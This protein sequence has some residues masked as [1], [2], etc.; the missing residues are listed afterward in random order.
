MVEC[1]SESKA[2]HYISCLQKKIWIFLRI[3]HSSYGSGFLKNVFCMEQIT[4]KKA[5]HIFYARDVRFQV[6][7]GKWISSFPIEEISNSFDGLF[8]LVLCIFPNIECGRAQVGKLL[9]LQRW[10]GMW[11]AFCVGSTRSSKNGGD[12][13]Y[14]TLVMVIALLNYSLAVHSKADTRKKCIRLKIYFHT[15][16]KK[17]IKRYK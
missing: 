10:K 15:S 3:K 8:F 5:N 16:K 12:E 4:E 11:E 17:N 6:T 1:F 7:I 2:L 14:K 9:E 13:F